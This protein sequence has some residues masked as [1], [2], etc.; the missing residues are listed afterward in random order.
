MAEVRAAIKRKY[1][2][3]NMEEKDMTKSE[4][5]KCNTI[6]HLAGAAT[7]CVGAGLAQIPCSDNFLI[8]PVQLA[9]TISLGKVFGINLTES[10]AKSA[11]GS[12]AAATVGRA[13]SQVAAGWIPVAGNVSNAVTAASL[14]EG[15]GWM[16]ANEFA[17]NGGEQ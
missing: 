12:A 1:N 9:M 3:D 4:K 16:L 8:T 14:T 17:Q 10:A 7:A 11:V 13:V 15:L 6:I 5:I 2:T